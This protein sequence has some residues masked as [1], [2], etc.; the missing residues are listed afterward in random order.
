MFI[1]Q[2]KRSGIEPRGPVWKTGTCRPSVGLF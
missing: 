2:E 1:V